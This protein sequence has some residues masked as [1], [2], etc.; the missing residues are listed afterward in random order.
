MC[1][2]KLAKSVSQ[3]KKLNNFF[4]LDQSLVKNLVKVIGPNMTRLCQFQLNALVGQQLM[5]CLYCII[6]PV[7]TTLS[8]QLIFVVQSPAIQ[9]LHPSKQLVDTFAS[10]KYCTL[11]ICT[12]LQITDLYRFQFNENLCC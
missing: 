3:F 2:V 4:S 7:C 9:S 5:Y 8:A 6:Q 1:L 11:Y 12:D 10:L